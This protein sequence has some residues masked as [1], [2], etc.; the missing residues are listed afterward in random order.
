MDEVEL[1][2][3]MIIAGTSLEL[4]RGYA[5]DISA[6]LTVAEEKLTGPLD[7]EFQIEILSRIETLKRM[8]ETFK[9]NIKV[10]KETC[11]GLIK[12]SA[13]FNEEPIKEPI[14]PGSR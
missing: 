14:K 1:A 13:A 2:R 9:T 8:L 5:R 4:N 3:Q 12:T 10:D 6:Q 11:R 7:R